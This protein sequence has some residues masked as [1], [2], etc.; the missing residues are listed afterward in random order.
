MKPSLAAAVAHRDC[1]PQYGL[2]HKHEAARTLNEITN[3]LPFLRLLGNSFDGADMVDSIA[4]ARA[5]PFLAQPRRPSESRPAE[6]RGRGVALQRAVKARTGVSERRGLII[7]G[8]LGG[9]L[10]R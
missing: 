4:R 9:R 1:I 3:D 6:G 8:A 2:H 7:D 5:T 10:L